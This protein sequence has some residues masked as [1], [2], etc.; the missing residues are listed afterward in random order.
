MVIYDFSMI[1]VRMKALIFV[2]LALLLSACGSGPDLGIP[3]TSYYT[4]GVTPQSY[5]LITECTLDMSRQCSCTS[6]SEEWPALSGTFK[7]V[8]R[9][10]LI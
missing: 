10:N 9:C 6:A 2:T 3:H 8:Y 1:G 5:V 7:T 4:S